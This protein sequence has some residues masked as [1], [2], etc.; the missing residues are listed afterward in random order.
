MSQMTIIYI[1]VAIGIIAI[2]FSFVRDTFI[3]K[4]TE[5]EP[6]ISQPAGNAGIIIPLQLQ[7]YERLVLLIERI[8]PENLVSRL[9]QPAVNKS[10]MQQLLVQTIKTEFDYNVAQQ[11]YVSSD[12][13]EA[14]R[15]VKEQLISLINRIAGQ[16]PP[17][18]SGMELNKK[19]LELVMKSEGPFPTQAALEVLNTEAKKL[20]KA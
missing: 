11:I 1:L 6:V 4:K 17:D 5:K 20:L 18:A 7:A 12:A 16:L 9:H 10:E 3:K 13:W 14:V 19:L 8:S 15:N 2:L